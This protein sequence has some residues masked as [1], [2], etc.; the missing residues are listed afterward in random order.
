MHA[1]AHM[2]TNARAGPDS[3]QT[4]IN[5]TYNCWLAIPVSNTQGSPPTHTADAHPARTRMHTHTHTLKPPQRRLV[6]PPLQT[7]PCP[8]Q[9]WHCGIQPCD[10]RRDDARSGL[11]GKGARLG[12]KLKFHKSL[13]LPRLMCGAAES[14]AL[15]EA[16]RAQLETFH[17]GCLRQMMGL[18]RG[19]DGPSTAEL[20]ARTSQANMAD[21]MRRHRVRW[22][23]HAARKPNDVMVKQL[24]FAHSIPGHPRPM[25]RPHLT[26]TWAAADRPPTRVGEP[27][28]VPGCVE[29]G[30][31]AGRALFYFISSFPYLFAF[32]DGGLGFEFC[33]LE[34][35]SSE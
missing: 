1:H 16:Q 5:I 32:D 20:L 4:A 15:T 31:S 35:C 19:P 6:L 17:S 2:N 7:C 13:V 18:H 28:T 12:S 26:M 21:H 27:S 29:R 3:R 24:L 25:G 33:V 22:L 9:A 34:A 23:G 14:W 30:W 10:I 11:S 8:G